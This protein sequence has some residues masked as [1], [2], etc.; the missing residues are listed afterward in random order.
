[1]RIR[2]R[3]LFDPCVRDP[4]RPDPDRHA[5]NASQSDKMMRI[6]PDPD[7][8]IPGNCRCKWF[9]DRETIIKIKLKKLAGLPVY[10][11]KSNEPSHAPKFEWPEMSTNFDFKFV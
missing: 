7:K 4:D 9:Y 6:Q 10:Y 11:I 1:M 8:G 3:R 2:I 5:L